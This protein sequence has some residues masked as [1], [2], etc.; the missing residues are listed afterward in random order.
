M[1][2]NEV[3]DK[4][5][6]VNKLTTARASL[7]LKAPFY[8]TLLMHLKFGLAECETACTDMKRILW[9]PNFLRRITLEEVQ[10]VMLHEVMHCVLNHIHRGKGKAH[11]LYN[12]AA[13]IVVNSII[14]QT[15]AVNEFLVDGESAMHL[16]PDGIEGREYTADQVYE[17]LIR[18]YEKFL[19]DVDTL[20]DEVRSEYGIQIDNHDIWD[21][22]PVSTELTEEWKLAI[23]EAAKKCFSLEDTPSFVRKLLDGEGYNPIINWRQVLH[24]FT[25]I[26]A[27]NYDFDFA[28][29]DHRFSNGDFIIPSFL[30]IEGEAIKNLWVLIDSSGSM[31]DK[32]LT[33]IM[34]EIEA[35]IN[36]FSNL[37]ARISCFDTS[38][39]EPMEFEDIEGLAKLKIEG[40]GGTSFKCIFDYLKDNMMTEPPVAIVIITDGYSRYPDAKASM[41]IPVLWFLINNSHDAP[42]GKS[43]HFSVE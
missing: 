32:M 31:D 24:D 21:V 9:D 19:D 34:K 14:M 43:V 5:E 6:L 40:G 15:Y 25:Q 12:F 11:K 39:T 13:D 16:A 20:S 18:K 26:V 17:M 23:K 30:E 36:Q 37:H 42:W 4:R 2:K 27:E 28:P 7:L 33:M 8:G 1:N 29:P 22:I 41:D 35:A 3:I 10:F 38:V